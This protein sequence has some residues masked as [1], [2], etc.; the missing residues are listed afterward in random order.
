MFNLFSDLKTT[1]TVVIGAVAFIAAKYG[2]NIDPET[3]IAFVLVIIFFLGLF[4][5]DSSAK[6]AV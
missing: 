3:Q 1:L 4:S 6:K 5:R 2:V